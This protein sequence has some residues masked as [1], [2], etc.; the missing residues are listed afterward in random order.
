MVICGGN[1][2]RRSDEAFLKSGFSV[3]VFMKEYRYPPSHTGLFSLFPQPISIIT[4]SE[5]Q[6][7]FLH[8]LKRVLQGNH[9]LS[10]NI[11]LL[12]QGMHL[13]G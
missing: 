8:Y 12:E 13:G 11:Q 7:V 3:L 6:H 2:H 9:I 10:L 1:A 5:C 4:V